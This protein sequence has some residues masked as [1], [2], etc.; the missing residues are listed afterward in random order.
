MVTVE[1]VLLLLVLEPLV[2]LPPVVLPL[3]VTLPV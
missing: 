1:S 3:I 2:A